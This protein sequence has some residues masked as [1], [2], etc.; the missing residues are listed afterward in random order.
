M[1]ENKKLI[2]AIIA[3]IAIVIVVFGATYA[4]WL[5][6]SNNNERTLVN[7]TVPNST[8]ALSAT[9]DGGT[10]SVSDLAPTTSC[11]NSNYASKSTV[12][13]TYTNNSDTIANVIADLTVTAFNAP[14]GTPG[15]TTDLSH[16]HYA[17]TTNPSSCSANLITSGTFT[18]KGTVGAKLF[19]NQPLQSNIPV[20]TTNGSKTMYLYVWLDSG[21]E[22]V[23]SG[24]EGITDPMQ[25]LT[26]ALTWSGTITNG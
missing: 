21:Y 26:F 2:I 13:L 3:V 20:G 24:T 16:L 19:V 25:D 14:H 1:K 10:M 5:W 8:E 17:L 6:N 11:T 7:L 22:H 9:I 15:A 12:V 18:N 4:Y 23:T